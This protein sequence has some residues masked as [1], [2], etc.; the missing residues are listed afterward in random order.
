M[1]KHITL[2]IFPM[3][4]TYSIVLA[5]NIGTD[6]TINQRKVPFSFSVFFFLVQTNANIYMPLFQFRRFSHYFFIPIRL[7][8]HSPSV[9][10]VYEYMFMC[11]G[12]LNYNL[13]FDFGK[14][15]TQQLIRNKS[16]A[17]ITF[18]N[19][20]KKKIKTTENLNEAIRN[21]QRKKFREWE[22]CLL[23]DKMSNSATFQRKMK[24][25]NK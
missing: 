9:P 10:A 24:N 1:C 5:G 6:K 3:F 19:K 16:W 25:N 15:S 7:L 21:S 17:K 23:C 20:K 14:W 22:K 4:C 11:K 12:M 8:F 18:F 2:H 13:V